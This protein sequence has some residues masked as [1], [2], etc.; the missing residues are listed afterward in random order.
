M[1][2]IWRDE[3]THETTLYMKGAAEIILSK[4]NRV[5][6]E[7]GQEVPLTLE[8]R[9]EIEHQQRQLSDN[10]ERVLGC[11][12]NVLDNNLFPEDYEYNS[13]AK[14]F[15]IGD[16]NE[17]YPQLHCFIGMIS[18]M[19]PPR[20]DVEDAIRRCREAHIRV[21]M[22]TGD[23]PSTASAIARK[24]GIIR[25]E[26]VVEIDNNDVLTADNCDKT[27]VM[28]RAITVTGAV[29]PK[30]NK[31][32]WD[33]ILMH[34]EIVFARTTP[35]HKLRIVQECQQRKHVVAVTGDGVNDAPALKKSDVGI[36]MGSGA[37]VAR[38]AAHI[39]LTD[40]KFSSIVVG[41]ENGRMSFD[42]LKK[43]ILY[44][45][46][47]GSFSELMPVLAYEK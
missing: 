44:L 22:V 41:I 23:H 9:E 17:Q 8:M 39:V 16:G 28:H 18:L 3:A 2:N 20:V 27:S 11:C 1:L 35:E 24:V 37:D 32:S 6:D 21:M 5:L 38:E 43:V 26:Q 46:P 31:E 13:E 12:S 42:N 34:D 47:A 45:L 36:A 14:N 19:D 40:S 15:P 7:N 4:C 29:L 30:L 10:G 25:N 33:R